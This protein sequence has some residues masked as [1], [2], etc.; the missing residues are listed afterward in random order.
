MQ[1][2]LKISGAI[3]V[4]G[5]VGA[6]SPDTSDFKSEA[7]GFIED[8]DGDVA[9]QLGQTFTD[10]TCEEPANKDTGTTYECTAVGA[11]GQTYGFTATI[12]GEN[13]FQLGGGQVVG[14]GEA[15]S[16]TTGGSGGTVTDTGE[17]APPGS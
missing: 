13:E 9:Q 2:L 12:T 17:S 6:C 14:G 11:D 5:L 3:L 7:E 15:T 8:E 4:V 16:T 10:A 1:R